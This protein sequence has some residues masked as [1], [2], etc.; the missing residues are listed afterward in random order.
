MNIERIIKWGQTTHEVRAMILTGSRASRNQTD[1]L[2]DYD[3]AIFGN[4]CNFISDDRWIENIDNYLICIHD[5]F[6]FLSYTIPTR[7]TIF[8]DISKVDFSFYPLEILSQLISDLP[9]AYNAGYGILIDKDELL[10]DMPLPDYKA[11]QCRKPD[12]KEFKRNFDE[13]WFEVYHVAKYL[14]RDDLWTAKLRDI[15]AKEKLRQMIEWNHAAD[16][17][18]NFAPGCDGK[19]MNSWIDKNILQQLE[20]CWSGFNKDD[21]IQSLQATIELYRKL[22]TDT[23][24]RLGY[25]YN[26]EVD[27]NISS[28]IE[29]LLKKN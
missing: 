6:I 16:F 12:E 26:K 2:S 9:D 20:Q 11:Y 25:D 4:D 27:K 18:W 1:F 14:W 19:R 7:L 17:N 24:R 5:K 28:F 3:I 21:N 13:F 22:S 8:K 23:A 15:A 10:R 29:N